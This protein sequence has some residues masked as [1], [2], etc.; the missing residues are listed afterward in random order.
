MT[1]NERMN[2]R[3]DIW[4]SLTR[5][6]QKKVSQLGISHVMLEVCNINDFKKITKSKKLLNDLITLKRST[7]RLVA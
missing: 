3:L 2:L 1:T 5:Q 4:F 6:Q 7:I